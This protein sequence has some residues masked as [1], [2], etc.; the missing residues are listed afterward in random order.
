MDYGCGKGRASIFLALMTHCRAV[1]I[2][3]KEELIQ[4]AQENLVSCGLKNVS[5]LWMKAE[6]YPVEDEDCFFFFN[7]FSE[8]ILQKVIGR[9]LL[10]WYKNPRKIR[11][12][13]YYPSD[14]AVALLI[15]T[16]ELAF[17][18]EIDCSDLFCGSGSRERIL[19]FE[20]ME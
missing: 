13:Y 11:L 8:V 1:G 15:T 19:I 6:S 9:I 18:D 2:D 17:S 7:P 10:S 4:T 14:E 12:F 16:Q 5:F 20:T 3:Y